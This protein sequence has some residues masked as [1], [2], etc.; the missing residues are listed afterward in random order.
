MTLDMANRMKDV[1]TALDEATGGMFRYAGSIA[2]VNAMLEDNIRLH[3]E[4]FGMEGFFG[5]LLEAGASALSTAG[6]GGR[7]T[8]TSDGALRTANQNPIEIKGENLRM[9][10]DVAERRRA[11]QLRPVNLTVN[12]TIS[13]PIINSIADYEQIRD[14]LT[15]DFVKATYEA[16][17]ANVRS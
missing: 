7:A 1:V 15:H 4:A 8:F 6:R 14:R 9:L 16:Y 2:E 3:A 13:N 11:E 5:N 10:M 12:P 17:Y